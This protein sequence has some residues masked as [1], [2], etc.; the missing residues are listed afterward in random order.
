MHTLTREMT[1]RPR[2]TTETADLD[3]LLTRCSKRGYRI[4]YDFLRNAADAEDAVQEALAISCRAHRQ[5]TEPAAMDAWF[6]RVLTRHCL[7][8]LRRRRLGRSLGLRWFAPG[9]ET[10][11]AAS[12]G[13]MKADRL[14]EQARQE[15]A[16]VDLVRHLPAKQMAA[17]VLR[18]GHGMSV[19]EVADTLGVGIGTAKTHLARAMSSLRKTTSENDHA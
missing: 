5:L 1:V 4:A 7:R 12:S 8:V 2:A 6:F 14:L 10:E 9:S 3:G 15:A 18:Y 13:H 17:V 11:K 19:G 16:L